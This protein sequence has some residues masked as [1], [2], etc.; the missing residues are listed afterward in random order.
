MP[1]QTRRFPGRR[2]REPDPEAATDPAKLHASALRLLA[3]RD[4]ATG[5][6]RQKLEQQGYDSALVAQ[7]LTEL[8]RAG[9]LNDARYAQNY[10][11]WHGERGEGPLRIEA[12]LTAMSVAPDLIQAAMAHAPDWKTKARDL[13]NRR[14]GPEPPKT[15]P[16]K[17][18]QSRFL[19]YRGFSSDHIRAALG[20][21]QG[22]DFE[23]EAAD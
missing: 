11:N 9:Y 14:F 6:L 13:R 10:V 21:T 1:F 5:E 4:F 19:Q 7:S 15:W 23:P 22:P 12:D 3:R 17:A 18:K 8:T 2:K 20:D 16:E